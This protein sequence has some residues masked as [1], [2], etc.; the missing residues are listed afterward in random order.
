MKESIV[1]IIFIN[2]KLAKVYDSEP[3]ISG[4]KF[5]DNLKDFL[6]NILM[7]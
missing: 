2:G 1:I 6:D 4:E 5:K 7:D 3:W